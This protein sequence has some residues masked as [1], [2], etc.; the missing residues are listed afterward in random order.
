VGYKHKKTKIKILLTNLGN[1]TGLDGSYQSWLTGFHRYIYVPKKIR[2]NVLYELSTLAKKENPDLIMINEISKGN[3]INFLRNLLGGYKQVEVGV[4]Y[5][6]KSLLRLI[7]VYHKK[8][9]AFFSKKN[10]NFERFYLKSGQKKS[11]YKLTLPE[12]LKLIFGHFALSKKTRKKQFKEI[13]SLVDFKKGMILGDFN[14]HDISELET[15]KNNLQFRSAHNEKT[16]PTSNPMYPTDMLI[17][18]EN[19]RVNSKILENKFSD[20]LPVIFE[21]EY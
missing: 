8:S 19:V 20:H 6:R 5:G 4:K 21:V 16:C 10:M 14:I 11:F 7:P 1:C 3:Q 13:E 18:S 17:H 12:N 15:I 2:E 9:N